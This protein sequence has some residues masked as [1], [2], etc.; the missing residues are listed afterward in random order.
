[1]D[2]RAVAGRAFERLLT[3][4]GRSPTEAI[5]ERVELRR[6]IEGRV[7]AL[8]GH[9]QVMVGRSVT[10]TRPSRAELRS[11]EVTVGVDG[12]AT[13]LID[14]S[15]LNPGTE[16]A[17]W[18]R[19]PNA[20]LDLPSTPGCSAMGR[21]VL[22]GEPGERLAV[23]R[24]PHQ[25]IV[26]VPEGWVVPVPGGVTDEAA[27]LTYLAVIAGHGVD[28]AGPAN[29][30][31]AVLGVGSIGA[32]AIA[33]AAA[34]NFE[35]V[36]AVARSDRGREVARQ[37]GAAEFITTDEVARRRFDVLIDATGDPEALRQA[38]SMTVDGGRVVQLGSPRGHSAFP[39]AEVQRRGLSVVGAHISTLATLHRRSRNGPDPFRRLADEYLSAVAAG[40]INAEPLIGSTLDPRE[41]TYNYRRL[42]SGAMT[43]GQLDWSRLP[44]SSRARAVHPLSL[45]LRARDTDQT[46]SR[47]AEVETEVGR[48]PSE[49]ASPVTDVLRVAI[50]GCG[51]IG[52]TNGR[53]AAAAAGVE[54]VISHD[55]SPELAKAAAL[56]TGGDRWTTNIDEALSVTQAD[57]V[58]LSVPHDQ[59]EPLA[60][61][62][63]E[64][65]LHLVV[66]KPLAHDLAS[67]AR[68]AATAA[69]HG[70]TLSCCFPGRYQS[71]VGQARRLITDG[72]LG[73]I[74]SI[75]I[76][77]HNDKPDGYWFGGFSGRAPSAWRTMRA[78]AG[79]G[80]IIMNLCHY[81]EFA[82]FLTGARAGRVAA[83]TWSGEGQE[84]EAIAG[85][86]MSLDDDTIVT[87]TGSGATRGRPHDSICVVG[88]NGT[89]EIGATPRAYS[90]RWAPGLPVGEW[91]PLTT[92]VGEQQARQ[93]YFERFARSVRL[94]EPPD[95]DGA[96]AVEVQRVIEAAYVSAASDPRGRMVRLD[97]L[98]A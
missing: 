3:S 85:L 32:L 65:G 58:V 55:L 79:G 20:R 76:D 73:P 87:M 72:L 6:R 2:P 64:R 35:P 62:A 84:V 37:C 78:R 60:R 51:D 59:H 70:V 8:R 40:R 13:V 81:I 89:I 5:A 28:L 97:E 48:Q 14:R 22:D 7:S 44:P 34:R 61:M 26:T 23:L 68:I 82:L 57:A 95:V 15:A 24:A 53:A 75:N 50:I 4:R 9:G 43:A 54:V 39:L 41:M 17:Q 92:T 94:G 66:E 11:V 12:M 31:I 83:L 98:P 29:A 49:E 1:M 21:R 10:I 27:A 93:H 38:V 46:E 71:E 86:V 74:R 52:L 63:A 77:F 25:S 42:G 45:Q 96:M 56:A 80:V 67:A 47:M 18:L 91:F 19:L 88:E 36:V 90:E 33:L 16:R 30:D 69:D